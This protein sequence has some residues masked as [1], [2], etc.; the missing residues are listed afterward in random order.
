MLTGAN[1]H[2]LIDIWLALGPPGESGSCGRSVCICRS[3]GSS[4]TKPTITEVL[5]EVSSKLD[6]LPACLLNIQLMALMSCIRPLF[7][8][9]L[10]AE[11]GG[12]LQ[13]WS[14]MSTDR[15]HDKKIIARTLRQ[16]QT[17]T[18]WGLSGS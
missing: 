11:A 14:L 18:E 8:Y 6:L 16:C 7:H 17:T 13:V 9:S 3:C 2:V 15:Q 10:S 1:L 12:I 4:Q 5:Y